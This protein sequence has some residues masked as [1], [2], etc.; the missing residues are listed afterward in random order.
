MADWITAFFV[1]LSALSTIYFYKWFYNPIHLIPTVGNSSFWLGVF[2]PPEEFLQILE[3]G[4]RRHHGSAFKILFRHRWMVVVSVSEMIDDFVKRPDEELS[5]MAANRETLQMERTLGLGTVEDP[6]HNDIVREKLTRSLP[7]LFPDIFEEITLAV[8]AY[9]PA[10]EKLWHPVDVMR[11]TQQ[12]IARVSNRA[13]VGDSACRMQEYLDLTI[14]FAGHMIQDATILNLFPSALRCVVAPLARHALSD[15]RRVIKCLQPLIDERQGNLRKYGSSWD[16]KPMDMLQWLIE[17]AESRGDTSYDAIVQRLMAGNF[18][19]IHTTSIALA[20]V[21]YYLAQYPD[22]LASI[23]E[24]VQ[25]V[26][27][28]DGWTKRGIDNMWKLDSLLKESQRLNA[29]T[30]VGM[31]RQAMQD[32]TFRNGM[33]IPSGTI[34]CAASYPTHHDS[35]IYANAEGFDPFRFARMREEDAT[36]ARHLFV[37][38]STEY[39]PFG[40]GKHACPGRYFAASELKAVIGYTA[41]HYD[42]KL[43]EDAE[44]PNNVYFGLSMFPSLDGKLLFKKR[45]VSA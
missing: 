35:A 2:R 15:R 16:K 21:L 8:P 24:E 32:V 11:V 1:S 28:E 5:A 36:G 4:Y 14:A 37:N 42:L 45:E 29:V 38:A 41:L 34:V 22:C 33:V 26:V 18:A 20:H 27:E 30:A 40:Y 43:P 12:L 23:R 44:K 31:H 10:D 25:R 17:A 9:I 39:M 19:A 7:V 3:D 13:F 6:Y